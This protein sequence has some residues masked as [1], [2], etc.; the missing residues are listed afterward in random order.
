MAK[1]QCA[2]CGTIHEGLE[3]PEKCP[4]CKAPSSKFA[5]IDKSAP[6]APKLQKIN[7]E[8]Y[9]IIKKLESVGFI[10]A[11]EWYKENYD[12]DLNEAKEAIFAIK[13][14]YNL[15]NVVSEYDETRVILESANSIS[16]AIKLYKEKYNVSQVEANRKVMNAVKVFNAENNGKTLNSG[17][18]IALL[19]A[20][21]STL[22]MFWIL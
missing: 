18:T 4:V 17:C 14:K 6:K 9:E 21:T 22:S 7:D 1:Y 11:A 15:E 20:I 13:N 8:D 16:E 12:C 10:E 2:I 5:L 3:A 19:I